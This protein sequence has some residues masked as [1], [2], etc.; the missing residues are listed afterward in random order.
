MS[1]G[2]TQVKALS[3]SEE[4][5]LLKRLVATA[6]ATVFAASDLRIPQV[7]ESDGDFERWAERLGWLGEEYVAADLSELEAVDAR[8]AQIRVRA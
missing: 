1:S 4:R 8:A 5:E 7:P 6:P 3:Q 2:S